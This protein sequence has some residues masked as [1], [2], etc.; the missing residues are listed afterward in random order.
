MNNI[1]RISMKILN[2]CMLIMTFV[3][4]ASTDERLVVSVRQENATLYTLYDSTIN[5][6][7]G[8]VY[9]AVATPI[10]GGLYALY[11]DLKFADIL[12]RRFFLA[13]SSATHFGVKTR[14]EVERE[15]AFREI[16][17]RG[18]KAGV[19]T[20]IVLACIVSWSNEIR[21]KMSGYMQ[22]T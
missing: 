10:T 17:N 18:A 2:I 19:S 11:A 8:G 3:V 21:Y 14:Q 12:A 13:I 20:I 22:R 6:I 5:G 7:K 4:Q 1:E 15:T 9:A 16:T